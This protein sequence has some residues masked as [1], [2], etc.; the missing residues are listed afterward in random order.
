MIAEF[1]AKKAELEVLELGE[2]PMATKDPATTVPDLE[3]AGKSI[4]EAVELYVNEQVRVGNWVER[5]RAK[6]EATLGVLVELVGCETPMN[7]VTKKHA[8]DVKA[9]LLTVPA[10]KNTTP[11][12]RKMTLREAAKVQGMPTLSPTTLNGYFG[13]F[14]TFADWAVKNAYAS[15]N[16]FEGIQC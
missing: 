3:G 2:A 13:A 8:Q 11:K 4:A 15:G 12:L 5:S 7:A 1:D 6:Q 14:F 10:R 16:A 9:V